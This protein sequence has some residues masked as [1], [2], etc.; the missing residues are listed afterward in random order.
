MHLHSQSTVILCAICILYTPHYTQPCQAKKAC[1]NWRYCILRPV[2]SHANAQW[3][4]VSHLNLLLPAYSAPVHI[5]VCTIRPVPA[6]CITSW[7]RNIRIDA[8]VMHI[9]RHN[10]YYIAT[11]HSSSRYYAALVLCLSKSSPYCIS[12]GACSWKAQRE[13]SSAI[14]KIWIEA[15]AMANE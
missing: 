8:Q 10:E 7:S 4:R 11:C 12:S 9:Y 6:V 15:L 5:S 14:I 1:T 13:T 3:T 2:T